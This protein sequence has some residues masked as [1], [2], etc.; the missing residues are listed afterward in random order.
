MHSSPKSIKL[1][2]DQLPPCTNQYP[3]HSLLDFTSILESERTH[4]LESVPFVS[5]F[6]LFTEI[7][8]Q[9][10]TRDFEHPVRDI[11]CHIIDSY[12]PLQKVLVVKMK[13]GAHEAAH[14]TFNNRLIRKLVFMDSADEGL[15]GNGSKSISSTSRSKEAD[16]AY[17]PLELPEGRSKEWP[18]LALES[19]YTNSK[20]MLENNAKWWVSASGGDV[21]VAVT[22]DIHEQRREVNVRTY[23]IQ[24]D[25]TIGEQL[26]TVSEEQGGRAHVSSAPLII[27]FHDLFLRDPTGNE[28]D[29][30]LDDND[31]RRL[32]KAIWDEQF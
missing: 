14:V 8:P 12:Y 7:G 1:V 18:T 15:Q 13:A 22:I 17:R 11:I 9:V 3:Y 32:G 21:K 26:V 23:R 6:I 24:S 4:F 29:I 19:G 2:L 5:Q 28:T 25:G 20:G 16:L 31:M 10:F 30:K 27:L